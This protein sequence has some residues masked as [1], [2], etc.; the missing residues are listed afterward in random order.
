[1]RGIR[2]K[3]GLWAVGAA[4]ALSAAAAGVAFA[5]DK[6]A[7]SGD[8]D[9]DDKDMSPMKRKERIK[10]ELGIDDATA[11]KLFAAMDN[12]RRAMKPLKEEMDEIKAAIEESLAAKTPDEKRVAELLG[13]FEANR[14]AAESERWLLS[15]TVKKILTPSQAARFLI[16]IMDKGG[17]HKG[18]KALG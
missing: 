6:K 18:D 3:A 15:D 14:K 8:M 1:M 17:K 4:L 16:L 11:L 9:G 5:G 2:G 13:K 7:P 10:A 12:H